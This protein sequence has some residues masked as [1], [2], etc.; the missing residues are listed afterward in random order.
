MSRLRVVL[1]VSFEYEARP[2]SY[3]DW[4]STDKKPLTAKDM[5]E[6]DLKNFQD[7][8]D[9]FWEMIDPPF[10]NSRPATWDWSG[11]VVDE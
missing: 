7:D 4:D 6:V 10:T 3:V 1:T 5:L 8:P 2:E 11:E 9:M